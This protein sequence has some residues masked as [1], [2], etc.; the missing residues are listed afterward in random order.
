MKHGTFKTLCLLAASLALAG[1][2]K[3]TPKKETVDETAD[4][5]E[6]NRVLVRMAFAENV[7]NGTAH[8]RAIYPKDFDYGAATLN[9]LGQQRV[10]ML[11]DAYR[12]ATGRI[13]VMRGDEPEAIHAE[14]VATVRKQF[15]DAG[16]E[17]EDVVVSKG[18]NLDVGSS[19]ER[20]IVTY[21][22][23]LETY[24]TPVGGG[25]NGSGG[26]FDINSK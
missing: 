3:S 24:K 20:A 19:S 11:I 2:C 26:D 17:K 9:T 23:L 12:K 22:R 14:R 18:G 15:A 6:S 5:I 8:A 21:N 25:S 4:S 16:Y 1:G 7:Y 10:A 13:I